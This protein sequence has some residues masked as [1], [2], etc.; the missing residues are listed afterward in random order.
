VTYVTYSKGI[1]RYLD[2]TFTI[3]GH[4]EE[5]WMSTLNHMAVFRAA[6]LG[7]R[8]SRDDTRN[9]GKDKA[10]RIARDP[11]DAKAFLPLHPVAHMYAV[12][13]AGT[14]LSAITVIIVAVISIL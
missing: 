4:L 14:L 7:S 8:A 3:N 13:A 5:A 1:P 6:I 9:P 2:G 11:K 10:S 12:V